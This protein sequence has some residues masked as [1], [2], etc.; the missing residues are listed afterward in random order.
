MARSACNRLDFTVKGTMSSARLQLRHRPRL[1]AAFWRKTQ[2]EGSGARNVAIESPD[3]QASGT[4]LPELPFTHAL[5]EELVKAITH[6]M[7]SRKRASTPSFSLFKAK[8][9][10]PS[11][12]AIAA[13]RRST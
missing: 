9:Q 4:S 1:R 7:L 11:P 2:S 12:A 13:E 6:S 8:Q 10:H 3:S 5:A